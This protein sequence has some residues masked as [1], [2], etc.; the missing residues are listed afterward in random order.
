MADS[1]TALAALNQARQWA[2]ENVDFDVSNVEVDGDYL[3]VDFRV[4]GPGG[5]VWFDDRNRI[6]HPRLWTEDGTTTPTTQYRRPSGETLFL[7]QAQFDALT[8]LQQRALTPTGKTW[9]KPNFQFAPRLALLKDLLH[10]AKL[11]TKDWTVP[12]V[13]RD[14]DGNLLGDTLTVFSQD[15]GNVNSSNANIATARAGSGLSANVASAS[16]DIQSSFAFSLYIFGMGFIAFDTSALGATATITGA[17]VSLAGDGNAESNANSPTIQ[18]KFKDYGAGNPTTADW[19]NITTT[20]WTGLV[21]V[22]GLALGSW[23]QTSGAYNAFSDAGNYGSISKTGVT[24]MVIG[25]SLFPTGTPTGTNEFFPRFSEQTGTTADPKLV[26]TYTASV[27][28]TM[29]ASFAGV[30]AMAPKVT[31]G[32]RPAASLAGV[33]AIAPKV[34]RGARPVA[35]LAGVGV[36]APKLTRGV[37]LASALASVGALSPALTRAPGGIAASLASVGAL[38]PALTRG[39]AFASTLTGVG[40]LSG[41]VVGEVHF[42][43]SLAGVGAL[44]PKLTRGVVFAAS[45]AGAGA[46]SAALLRRAALAATLTGAGAVSPALHRQA[47]FKAS[48]TGV[49]AVSPKLTRGVHIAISL[50]GVGTISAALTQVVIVRVTSRQ[51]P[52][53]YIHD[54]DSLERIAQLTRVHSINRSFALR[55]HVRQAQFTILRSDPSYLDTATRYAH[56]IVIE[57]TE[58]PIPWVGRIVERERAEDGAAATVTADSYEAILGERYLPFDFDTRATGTAEAF[59]RI[60]ATVNGQNATGI[61]LGYIEEDDVP[62]LSLPDVAG[63]DAVDQL[64][65]VANMEWWLT[66]SILDGALRIFVDMARE[67]G[68]DYS[69]SVTLSGPGGNFELVSWRE[70]NRAAAYRQ[71]VIGGQSEVLEAW[72]ERERGSAVRDNATRRTDIDEIVSEGARVLRFGHI[73]ASDTSFSAPTTRRERRAVIEALKA[74]GGAALA[75]KALLER[76]DLPGGVIIGRVYP[77]DL[78]TWQALE[79]GNVVWFSH[80]EPFDDG[81]EGPAAVTGAQPMESERFVE[82]TLEVA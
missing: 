36:L 70:N 3:I 56:V 82:V 18:I 60:L 51:R 41:T 32:A 78:A 35:S 43:A 38:A 12:H 44:S 67:R 69:S 29:A 68:A 22:G 39:V 2:L 54:G 71:T 27:A 66:H 19:F 49:G 50:H 76:R 62:A 5:K 45:L 17:I 13:M 33:G 14:A 25:T 11:V 4:T 42:A 57:S 37:T 30:G 55:E 53:L 8:R 58:Y 79:P 1:D 74:E 52:R 16:S 6:L 48:L 81:Y 26:I 20:G 15:D 40:A 73:I 63:V 34:T 21:D 61:G 9:D 72:S 46:L 23:N 24:R 47:T 64:A 10:T 80:P 75:S 59:R 65:Q 31:R 28:H 77:D 7:S